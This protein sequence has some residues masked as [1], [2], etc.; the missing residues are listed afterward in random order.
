[1]NWRSQLQDLAAGG[2]RVTLL[3][4]RNLELNP[5]QHLR[6]PHELLRKV[7]IAT[8]KLVHLVAHDE[9][10]AVL[11]AQGLDAALEIL[12]RRR[13][14]R[15]SW[16]SA[17]ALLFY[18]PLQGRRQLSQVELRALPGAALAAGGGPPRGGREHAALA[19]RVHRARGGE[20]PR[21]GHA[22]AAPKG[23]GPRG[24]RR[25][26]VPPLAAPGATPAAGASAAALA[27]LVGGAPAAGEALA[28]LAC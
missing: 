20:Q 23:L 7:R 18:R 17:T 3:A 4:Q 11:D 10:V 16:C 12:L 14:R 13:W 22:S 21:R 2:L 6:I 9:A 1:M 15:R 8:I 27:A 24:P 25:R 5:V 26:L 28:A 19:L